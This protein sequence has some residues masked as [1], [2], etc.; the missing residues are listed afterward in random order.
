[1]VLILLIIEKCAGTS[2]DGGSMKDYISYYITHRP[3]LNNISL[4]GRLNSCA[5]PRTVQE[6]SG[7][8]ESRLLWR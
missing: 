1:M 4:H 5:A 7:G 3:T 8:F 6:S 2:V